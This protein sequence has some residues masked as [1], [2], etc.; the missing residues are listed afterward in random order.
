MTKSEFK[1]T[2]VP[3]FNANCKDLALDKLSTNGVLLVL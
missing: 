1:Y 3:D 2:R